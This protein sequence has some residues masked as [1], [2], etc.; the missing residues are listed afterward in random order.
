MRTWTERDVGG[1]DPYGGGV[2]W[3]PVLTDAAAAWWVATGR[4]AVDQ[5]RQVTVADEHLQ[6]ARDADVTAGD[7]VVKVVD[8]RGRVIFDAAAQGSGV[9]REV[10][11]VAVLRD[12]VDCSLRSTT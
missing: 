1:S 5:Q 3:Q 7:R 4:E 8:H 10:E 2:D 11:H 9:A 6:L 12:H